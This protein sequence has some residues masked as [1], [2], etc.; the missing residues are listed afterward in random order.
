MI[1]ERETQGTGDPITVEE[2]LS[3]ERYQNAS[4]AEYI[5]ATDEVRFITDDERSDEEAPWAEPV[6]DPDDPPPGEPV[7]DTRP[8]DEWA[9]AECGAVIAKYIGRVTRNR[10]G[11][12]ANRGDSTEGGMLIGPRQSPSGRI[13]FITLTSYVNQDEEPVFTP[14]PTFEQVVSAVPATATITISFEGRE[15]TTTFPVTVAEEIRQLPSHLA[16]LNADDLGQASGEYESIAE[17][18]RAVPFVFQ[19]PDDLPDGY[20]LTQITVSG[21]SPTDGYNGRLVYMS[22]SGDHSEDLLVSARPADEPNVPGHPCGVDQEITVN[23]QPGT[24]AKTDYE[25]IGA[26]PEGVSDPAELQ[27]GI[28]E[29]ISVSETYYYLNGPFEKDELIQIAESIEKD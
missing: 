24:Y 19:G 4:Q 5:A 13:I 7:Y 22:D 3:P 9:D 8:F 15:Y 16:H 23:D 28:L 2:T 17:A 26:L 14:R 12:A 1:E 27:D 20:R 29:F 21:P 6:P 25:I 11:A 10:L 18:N